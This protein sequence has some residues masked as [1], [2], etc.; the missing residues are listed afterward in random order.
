MT[1]ARRAGGPVAALAATIL[2]WG[3]VP[4]IL[5]H[6]A[7]EGLLD[8]WTVNGVRYL[9]TALFWLPFLLANRRELAAQRGIWRH[10][11][12]PAAC[13]LLGQ[14]GWGLAPYYNTAN[15]M[16]FVSRLSFLFSILLGF[17]L[18][19]DERRLAR[20]PAFW[21]GAALTIAGIV[22]LFGGGLRDGDTSPLG[23]VILVVTAFCWSAYGVTVRSRM[24]R[25]S[26]RL[27]FGVVSLLVAPP[28]TALM[29]GLGDWH[30]ALHLDARHWLM[31]AFTGCI[32]IA[33]GHVLFYQGL[34]AL[35]PIVTEG[36]LCLVPFLTASLS[37]LLLHEA[38]GPLQWAGG[39]LLV[40][41]SLALLAAKAR[42]PREEPPVDTA[43]SG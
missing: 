33:L 32:A 2:I 18:L 23:L 15:V 24:Q 6:I 25:Y 11:A 17:G 16:N 31:L 4:L 13:H 30:A 22:A 1:S 3:V 27:G 7:R 37:G 38:M 14:I 40:A 5:R 12:V 29:F 36:S 20:H 43:A 19:P 10:A 8:A 35:G 26:S 41:G 34:R 28:L 21:G 39:I 42:L 9:F